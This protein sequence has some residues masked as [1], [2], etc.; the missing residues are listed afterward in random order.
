MADARPLSAQARIEYDVAKRSLKDA[1]QY[2][3]DCIKAEAVTA[4]FEESGIRGKFN[5]ASNANS[6]VLRNDDS[7]GRLI[8]RFNHTKDE[9][10][11]FLSTHTTLAGGV[12]E[13][14]EAITPENVESFE[15]TP[16]QVYFLEWSRSWEAHVLRFWR[17]FT[18]F[19]TIEEVIADL[20]QIHEAVYSTSTIK[21]AAK[22]E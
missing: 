21:S 1:R 8:I 4:G 6:I 17:G 3:M 15:L 19:L 18:I 20:K 7:R 5:G 22:T 13:E 12:V 10:N 11:W 2:D 14:W 9:S 16:A